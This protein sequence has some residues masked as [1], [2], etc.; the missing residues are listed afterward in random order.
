MST[1][2]C[3]TCDLKFEAEG[4]KHEFEALINAEIVFI[5]CAK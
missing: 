1:F 5:N 4:T 2:F 3:K